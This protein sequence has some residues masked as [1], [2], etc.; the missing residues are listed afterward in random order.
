MQSIA[1][2]GMNAISRHAIAR[3]KL[4][5]WLSGGL[6]ALML[7]L[8][9]A[10][11]FSTGVARA[12]HPLTIDTDP[13]NMLPVEAPVRVFHNEMKALFDLHDMIVVG[14]VNPERGVFTP[15]TLADIDH[16]T[17]VA[18]AA[19]WQDDGLPRGAVSAEIIA[20]GM[21]DYVAQ[22]G[23]GAVQFRWLMESP[24]ADAE[25]ALVVA[26]NAKA[27][28]M[29]DNSL[30]S[31]AGD[32]LALYVPIHHKEDSYLVAKQLRAAIDT[33]DNGDTYHIT[34]LPI[35]QD[36]FGIE[37]F[38]QMAISAPAAMMLIYGL[39]WFFFRQ[40]NVIIAPMVVAMVSVLVTMGALVITGNTVHIMSSMIPIFIMPIAVLD[41][42]HLLSAFHDTY[43]RYKDRQKTLAHVLQDLWK[44]MLFT[45]LTTA[46]GFASLAMA[47]I[48]PVQ[49][50]GIFVALGV[51]LAWLATMALVPAYLVLMPE[52]H[53][54]QFCRKSAVEIETTRLTRILHGMGRFAYHGK[55]VVLGV[56]LALYGVSYYGIS[57]IQIND[58]P[59]KW[60]HAGHEIR[61][62]DADL[63]ARFAGTYMAYLAFDAGPFAALDAAEVEALPE[64]ARSG[65]Q[66][67]L[68]EP[69]NDLYALAEERIVEETDDASRAAWLAALDLLD[70]KA[71]EAELFKSP[72]VLRWIEAL[73]AHAQ[74]HPNV[75]KTNS[76]NE[77]IKTVHRELNL[78]E[79]KDYRIPDS[80]SAVAQTL[81][82]F[83]SSHRPTDLWHFVTPDF[84]QANLW[85]QLRSGDNADM[86]AVSEAVDAWIAENPPPAAL[87]HDWFGLTY[88]NVVWQQE[89]VAGMLTAFL[90]S[91]VIVLAMMVLLFRS[92]SWGILSMVP[93]TLSIGVIYGLLGIVGKDYDMPIAVLSSLSLG[94][95]I[96]YAI[97]F[98]QRSR[99]LEAATLNWKDALQGVTGEPARAIYRNIIIVGVGFLPLLLAP[100]TPYNTVG[101]FI[102][103]I[104]LVSGLASLL[105]LPALITLLQSWLFNRPARARTEAA[106]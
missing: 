59:V 4:W 6:V 100:L 95:A 10:P 104:L 20:P 38:I 28:P 31:E 30:I 101:V 11:T 94:L 3:P 35:A 23:A 69:L 70:A 13:E 53:I 47:D 50:F 1:P 55:Y 12:L 64:P 91:F 78:G 89:M 33:F 26:R 106:E 82:T 48:P 72:E 81:L 8:V 19:T 85:F 16:L 5:F 56:A 96:D 61:V 29:L 41:A 49:V 46:V 36:Q 103:L 97:H 7:A 45:S 86:V 43:P 102:S 68:S 98:V 66:A 92:V 74:D 34:G 51:L 15:E 24:P 44:P 40:W 52:R 54:E 2:D 99:A 76:V 93:L 25:A 37:M 18:R 58:N 65:L 42:V 63:N 79:A 84:R 88:I 80:Q 22:D 57:R 21:V 90:S 71:A 62:A 17:E 14:V 77:I 67:R 75:G 9:L 105:I 83:E 73:Q 87:S 32:A 27:M 60:F 39:M